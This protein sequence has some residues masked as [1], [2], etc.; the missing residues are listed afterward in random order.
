MLLLAATPP[1]LH[2]A[3]ILTFAQ[4]G[5]KADSARLLTPG[6]G[7]RYPCD[8]DRQEK[9]STVLLLR[10]SVAALTQHLNALSGNRVQVDGV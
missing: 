6:T 2:V 1:H 5:P 9:K 8:A 10:A 7:R 3:N 4:A